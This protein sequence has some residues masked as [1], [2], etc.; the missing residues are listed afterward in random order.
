ALRELGA[1][2]VQVDGS[3]AGDGGGALAGIAALDLTGIRA[4]PAGGALI[5]GD[6]DA[7]LTGPAGAAAVYGP[8]KGAT[9]ADVRA[10][11]AGLAHL[12]GLLRVDPATAGAG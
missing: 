8:Q 9:S 12:A 3:P 10:L 11:D 2:A 6:V 7:P 4:L 5:L 1:R